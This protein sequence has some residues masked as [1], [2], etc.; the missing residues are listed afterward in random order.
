M[1]TQSRLLRRAAPMIPFSTV[2][3]DATGDH[4]D[5]DGKPLPAGCVWMIVDSHGLIID[6][7]RLRLRGCS[8]LLSAVKRYA[9]S[10]RGVV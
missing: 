1:S 2:L 4:R 10:G 3:I 5:G 9:N 7:H 6:L 8:G